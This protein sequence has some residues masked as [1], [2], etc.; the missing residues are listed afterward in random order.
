MRNRLML[1]IVAMMAMLAPVACLP[2]ADAATRTQ[3][4]TA[5]YGDY[6][7]DGC[8]GFADERGSQ[9]RKEVTVKVLPGQVDADVG[10]RLS[11]YSHYYYCPQGDQPN[12]IQIFKNVFCAMKTDNRDP[13]AL[14]GFKFNPY[15]FTLGDSDTVV[16][17]PEDMIQWG[18]QG[19]SGDEHC[20]TQTVPKEDRAWMRVRQS[21][22]WKLHGTTAYGFGIPDDGYDFYAGS[23]YVREYDPGS[24]IRYQP[25]I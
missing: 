21:P 22:A 9:W 3:T 17:P 15:H 23:D 20:T 8:D 5:A 10:F 19:D 18:G 13:A 7:V 6:H 12:K 14:Q 2:S 24:D 4:R 16:N 11:A 1:M 25:G